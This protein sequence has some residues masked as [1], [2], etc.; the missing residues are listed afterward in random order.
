MKTI[1]SIKNI[2]SWNR[3]FHIYIGLFLLLFIWLFSLSGLLLN[4]SQ[5]KFASFWD[6]RKESE[7]ITP[8]NIPASLDS[9][10]LILTIMDQLNLSGEISNVKITPVSVDFR[11][12]I[13]GTIREIHVDLKDKFSIQKQTVFNFWGKMR[14]LHTFN[15]LNKT[16]PEIKSNWF[17]TRIWALAMDGVALGLILLCFSSWLMWYEVR[18]NYSKGVYVLIL[19]LAICLYF[20]FLIRLL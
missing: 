7:I 3:K 11:V 1:S 4:H 13:P 2:L 16:N 18:K 8:V 19:G 10:A 12:I 5:W 17:F 14:V 6:Q 9:S 15:G 20:I